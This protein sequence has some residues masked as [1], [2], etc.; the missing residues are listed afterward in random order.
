MAYDSKA[1]TFAVHPALL[2][3]V[4]CKQEAARVEMG[5]VSL[6]YMTPDPESD[7]EAQSASQIE[8]GD[9]DAGQSEEFHA[10]KKKRIELQTQLAEKPVGEQASGQNTEQNLGLLRRVSPRDAL[11][12]GYTVLVVDTNF[13][14]SS[15]HIFKLTIANNWSIVIPNTGVYP[16]YNNR[17]MPSTC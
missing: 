13:M 4:H 7:T 11:R 10:L 15:L 9:E 8:D 2:E 17:T 12:Q 3:R 5:E 16:L 14:L 6:Q 1:D